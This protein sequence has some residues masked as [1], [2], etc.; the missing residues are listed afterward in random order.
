MRGETGGESGAQL[1]TTLR[2]TLLPSHGFGHEFGPV[3]FA[4]GTVGSKGTMINKSL[5]RFSCFTWTGA[6]GE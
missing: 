1:G 6:T 5:A 4:Q 2:I 3:K